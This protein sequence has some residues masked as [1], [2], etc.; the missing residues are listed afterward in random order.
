MLGSIWWSAT[1]NTLWQHHPT[2]APACK[3]RKSDLQFAVHCLESRGAPQKEKEG[4]GDKWWL[5]PEY[6]GQSMLSCCECCSLMITEAG[7]KQ[8]R[9]TTSAFLGRQ[10]WTLLLLKWRGSDYLLLLSRCGWPK[11]CRWGVDSKKLLTLVIH[12]CLPVLTDNELDSELSPKQL[13]RLD[14]AFVVA[15]TRALSGGTGEEIK[16]ACSVLRRHTAPY[17]P[18]S[19][20]LP[21]RGN[22]ARNCCYWRSAKKSLREQW[23]LAMEFFP[24]FSM[25]QRQTQASAA[26]V[27]ADTSSQQYISTTAIKYFKVVSW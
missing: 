12:K 8:S 25:N 5:I 26:G 2:V 10:C 16:G 13:L 14:F 3:H 27:A 6:G 22:H 11:E 7:E 23:Q 20:S 1:L 19:L 4:K 17:L 24:L 9:A 18:I 21:A 15:S